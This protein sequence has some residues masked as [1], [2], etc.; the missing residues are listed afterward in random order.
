[1]KALYIQPTVDARTGQ[2]NICDDESIFFDKRANALFSNR[3][4]ATLNPGLFIVNFAA[5]RRE[6]DYDT[7]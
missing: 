1:M 7:G 4:I 5:R 2:E 3:V 6:Y